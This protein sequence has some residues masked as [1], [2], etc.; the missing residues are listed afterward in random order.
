ME[1]K[2]PIHKEPLKFEDHEITQELQQEESKTAGA[3][4][5]N[6]S[7]CLSPGQ[8][9]HLLAVRPPIPSV[10]HFRMSFGFAF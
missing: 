6:I 7:V 2:I 10:S 9:I 1:G 5:D 4:R 8:E 3:K